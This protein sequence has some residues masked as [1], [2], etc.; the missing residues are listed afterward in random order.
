[1]KENPKRQL[2]FTNQYNNR[3]SNLFEFPATVF[4]NEWFKFKLGTSI[5]WWSNY[6]K[7]C[8]WSGINTKN[9]NLPRSFSLSSSHNKNSIKSNQRAKTS[10]NWMM[11]Y[12]QKRTWPLS[13][14]FVLTF[15]LSFVTKASESRMLWS[16]GDNNFADSDNINHPPQSFEE[17][18]ATAHQHQAQL[19][20][21]PPSQMSDQMVQGNSR[22]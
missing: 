2:Y 4:L 22:K 18:S 20:E 19:P 1:M 21:F 7:E 13:L 6:L 5:D 16:F 12:H 11:R 8:N 10:N 17:I 15:F 3:I 9:I 14:A